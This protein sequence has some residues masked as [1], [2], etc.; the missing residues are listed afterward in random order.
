M[1]RRE[2]FVAVME[3]AAVNIAR[4]VATRKARVR[5][6][7]LSLGQNSKHRW[8]FGAF[9]RAIMPYFLTDYVTQ[10]E[11]VIRK[12]ANLPKVT[13]GSIVNTTCES[14]LKQNR[15][16]CLSYGSPQEGTAALKKEKDPGPG[17]WCSHFAF[18]YQRWIHRSTF[19]GCRG[20]KSVR[21]CRCLLKVPLMD[22]VIV[23]TYH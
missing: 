5:V 16:S 13:V 15:I 4:A 2:N 22:R 3:A 20:Q 21:D 10:L 19:E 11:S 9:Q 14:C 17:L 8:T 23:F 6:G 12:P 18:L 1:I 7:I